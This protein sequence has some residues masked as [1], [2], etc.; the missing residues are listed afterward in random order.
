MHRCLFRKAGG[1]FLCTGLGSCAM[2]QAPSSVAVFLSLLTRKSNTPVL[3]FLDVVQQHHPEHCRAQSYPLC[4]RAGI[5]LIRDL[6]KG[7]FMRPY[8]EDASTAKARLVLRDRSSY[9]SYP[10]PYRNACSCVDEER[11]FRS[12]RVDLLSL[13]ARTIHHL[14]CRLVD[15]LLGLVEAR[16]P[17]KLTLPQTLCSD[18]ARL[19]NGRTSRA[20]RNEEKD[21][22]EEISEKTGVEVIHGRLQL[23]ILGSYRRG[24]ASLRE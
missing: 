14:A 12:T 17:L 9:S 19:G 3:S 21:V 15:L 23:D 22:D 13:P 24:Q 6:V 11:R 7:V 1:G 5:V 20:P 18:V 8:R 10:D 2:S 4:F 16:E